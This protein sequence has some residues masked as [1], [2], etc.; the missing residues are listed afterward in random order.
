MTED[1][2]T[3]DDPSLDVAA[4]AVSAAEW[5]RRRGNTTY[6]FWRHRQP[7]WRL[8]YRIDDIGGRFASSAERWS[9]G[10]DAVDE[11]GSPL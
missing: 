2:A 8:V 11:A 6:V 9:G 4:I 5:L 10:M 3:Q 7:G 1:I